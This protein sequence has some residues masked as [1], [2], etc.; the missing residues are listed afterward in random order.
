MKNVDS[1]IFN[2]KNE[3]G[4]NSANE[5]MLRVVGKSQIIGGSLNIGILQCGNSFKYAIVF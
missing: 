4:Q 2:P 1:L 5:P 3:F